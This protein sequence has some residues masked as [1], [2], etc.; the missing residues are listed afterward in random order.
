MTTDHGEALQAADLLRAVHDL[1]GR[2]PGAVIAGPTAAA[3]WIGELSGLAPGDDREAGASL[4]PSLAAGPLEAVVPGTGGRSSPEVRMRA[5]RLDADEIH[6]VLDRAGRHLRLTSPLR[7]CFDLARTLH[8]DEAVAVVDAVA[9]RHGTTA[10]DLRLLAH[11][12]P[13]VRGRR[14]VFPVADLMDHGSTSPGRTRVRLVLRRAGIDVPLAGRA[15]VD[16]DGELLGEL[17]LLWPDDGCG[18]QVG[19]TREEAIARMGRLAERGWYVRLVPEDGPADWLRYQALGLLEQRRGRTYPPL[20][21]RSAR[22]RRPRSV[23]SSPG[24]RRDPGRRARRRRAWSRGRAGP[25]TPARG[26]APRCPP[27][28]GS[29]RGRARPR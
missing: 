8:A 6:E 23:R 3:L 5:D 2:R 18:M 20:V 11:H 28:S 14:S 17:D 21:T 26:P 19:R 13:G 7:T 4:L 22:R 12:H 10:E 9:A 1:L 29:G 27:T 16:S 15:V 25:S 24:S